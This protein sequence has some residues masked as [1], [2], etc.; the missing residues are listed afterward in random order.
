MFEP[1]MVVTREQY[2]QFLYNAINMKEKPTT[3]PEKK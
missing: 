1:K 3:E 2:A